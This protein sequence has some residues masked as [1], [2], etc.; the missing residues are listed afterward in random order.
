MGITEIMAEATPAEVAQM[1]F[2]ILGIPFCFMVFLTFILKFFVALNSTPD[3]RAFWTVGPAYVIVT[4]VFLFSDMGS[5]FLKLAFPL[6]AVPM[7]L[8]IYWWW[9]RDFRAAWVDDVADLPE[10][11]GLANSDWRIGLGVVIALFV[12]SAIRVFF[13]QSS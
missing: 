2:I 12:A 5:S 10:G 8:L 4:L 1:A 9:R 6:A 11:R 7:A 3:R 13:I